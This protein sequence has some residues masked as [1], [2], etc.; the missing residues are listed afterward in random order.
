MTE[1]TVEQLL[2]QATRI[3]R[4]PFDAAI[5]LVCWQDH[6]TGLTKMRH[7]RVGNLFAVD[8]MVR[9]LLRME[10]NSDLADELADKL[11]TD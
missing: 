8:G 9:Q 10:D 6:E 5:I 7:M 4:E 2:G 11:A 1:E 3:I